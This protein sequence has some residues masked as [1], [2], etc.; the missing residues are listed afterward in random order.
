MSFT[1]AKPAGWS[2]GDQLTATQIN[3]LDLDHSRAV[4]GYAG[5]V[6]TPSSPIG[7]QGTG[8]FYGNVKSGQTVTLESGATLSCA[9]SSII[10]FASGS[11]IS[12]YGNVTYE[13]AN[14]PKLSSRSLQRPQRAAWYHGSDWA[15]A[16]GGTIWV[17]QDDTASKIWLR[18]YIEKGCTVDSVSVWIDGAAH[19]GSWP[20]ENMPTA[21]VYAIDLENLSSTA[22]G[23]TAD[24]SAQSPYEDDHDIPVTCAAHTWTDTEIMFIEVTNEN[25]T[26]AVAGLQLHGCIIYMTVTEIRPF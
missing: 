14:Y 5:G 20:P 15:P 3:A 10:S 17:A 11:N 25:G 19:G 13:S 23:N 8:G 4:D 9:G 16:S 24:T 12:I 6:Y 26:N 1:R 18:E 22:L 21:Y 2:T 7:L